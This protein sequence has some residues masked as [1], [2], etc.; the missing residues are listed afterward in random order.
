VVTYNDL[1]RSSPVKSCDFS[2]TLNPDPDSDDGS[3]AGG[4]STIKFELTFNHESHRF[5]G[6]VT[7]VHESRRRI[8]SAGTNAA[9]T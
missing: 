7:A 6:L 4:F 5:A 3:F 1:G 2:S 8:G 9:G